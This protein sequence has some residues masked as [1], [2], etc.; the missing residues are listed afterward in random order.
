MSVFN[1]DNDTQSE[2]NEDS[3]TQSESNELNLETNTQSESYITLVSSQKT[4][5]KCPIHVLFISNI[6]SNMLEFD[7]DEDI[8][9]LNVNDKCMKKIIEYMKYYHND[10]MNN[11]EKPLISS[12]LKDIIQV[13]YVNFI[14]IEQEFLF[15]LVQAAN[16]LDIQPLLNLCCA[17]IASMIKNK[18]SDEIKEI[19]N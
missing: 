15:S 18:T 14:D 2:S 4:K 3:D 13:W 16:Y 19:F 8:P 10:N 12:D 17:K 5:F 1:L 6:I 7:N 9:L 11:I